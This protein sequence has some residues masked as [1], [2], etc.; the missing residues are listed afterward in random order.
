[1]LCACT[2]VIDREYSFN[3][4]LGERFLL[5]RTRPV[6][7][8]K[9][10]ARALR[11]QATAGMHRRRIRDAVGQ[12]LAACRL[13]RPPIP[14]LLAVPLSACATFVAMAR[15]PVHFTQKGEMEMAFDAEGS[16]RLVKQLA[17]LAQALAVV[18]GE[19][20]VT[21]RTFET[22]QAIAWD[23]M[24]GPRARTL[25]QLRELEPLGGL[26]AMLPTTSAVAGTL[27]LPTSTTRNYLFELTSVGL[28]ERR[29]AADGERNIDKWR[30]SA[31]LED[32]IAAMEAK[33]D[34]PGAD[35]SEAPTEG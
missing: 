14:E 17:T 24:P 3:A 9:V 6:D 7:W 5:C 22:V 2:Q 21:P 26:E 11:E 8:R 33:A 10:S 28:V 23:C 34:E 19:G 29:V 18:R 32:L 25:R 4:L 30:S 12:C 16:G 35:A 31:T 20:E 1:M 13:E 15:S 27:G